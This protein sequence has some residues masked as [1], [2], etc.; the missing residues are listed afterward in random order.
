MFTPYIKF[1]LCELAFSPMSSAFDWKSSTFSGIWH[2]LKPTSWE[3]QSSWWLLLH[4]TALVWRRNDEPG[5]VKVVHSL[6]VLLFCWNG[7]CRAKKIWVYQVKQ[8]QMNQLPHVLSQRRT[9]QTTP[10]HK[11][12]DLISARCVHV[13]V[14]GHFWHH[15]LCF[16]CLEM[17]VNMSNFFWSLLF[18]LKSS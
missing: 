1:A 17:Q 10:N 4:S 9:D 16:F 12:T 15:E 11:C 3:W 18:A 14:W 8:V 7:R 2:F 6:N 5:C 13:N